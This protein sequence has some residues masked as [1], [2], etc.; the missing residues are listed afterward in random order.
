MDYDDWADFMM[1]VAEDA[2]FELFLASS[3][4]GFGLHRIPAEGPVLSEESP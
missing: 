4:K 3:K 1:D 2:G